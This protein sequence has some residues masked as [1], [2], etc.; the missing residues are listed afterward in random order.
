M[1]N[2]HPFLIFW[3]YF[4]SC[5]QLTKE[6]SKWFPSVLTIL[7]PSVLTIWPLSVLTIWSPRVL[8]T[9]TKQ[10]CLIIWLLLWHFS[11]VIQPIRIYNRMSPFHFKKKLHPSNLIFRSALS[12]W[13]SS[14]IFFFF[15]GLIG[16]VCSTFE[17]CR[18]IVLMSLVWTRYPLGSI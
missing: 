5:S 7:S 12:T 6:S 14:L 1:A 17:N 18:V 15:F 16:G 10:S 11:K 3:A 2:T 8:P 9:V 4:M 13:F